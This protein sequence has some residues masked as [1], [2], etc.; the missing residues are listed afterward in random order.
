MT[1]A[2][3]T[4]AASGMGRACARRFAAAGCHVAALDVDPEGLHALAAETDGLVLPLEVD[5]RDAE[6][7]RAAVETATARLGAPTACVN[8][9]GVF[10]PSTLA[11][12]DVALYRRILD[13][14]LLGTVLVCQAVAGAMRGAGGGAIVNF[15]SVDGLAPS[16]GQLLYCASK[17]AVVMLTRC[18]A[19]ELAP[20]IRVNAIAPGWVDTEGNRATGR[21]DGA[22]ATVPLGRVGTP[23]EIA[24]LV[25]FLVAGAGAGFVTGETLVA[26]GGS[27][28][29]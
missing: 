20:A 5:I 17:A 2:L 13:T 4:G 1:T 9:A 15:A 23:E 14:N 29:R 16:P 28:V 18:L 24:E 21:M 19:L 26:S 6:G 3:V 10:P 22:A 7:V 8:A 27:L 25:W 11:T 12:A